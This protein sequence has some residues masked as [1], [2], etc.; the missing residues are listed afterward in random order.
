MSYLT[1]RSVHAH[2]IAMYAQ[3]A[4][5]VWYNAS[6]GKILEFVFEKVSVS[7]FSA[8]KSFDL[9]ATQWNAAKDIEKAAM[10]GGNGGGGKMKKKSTPGKKNSNPFFKFVYVDDKCLVGRGKGGGLALWSREEEA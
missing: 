7:L 4:A 1:S 6:Q 8:S 2:F 10:Q 9:D 5:F 3:P